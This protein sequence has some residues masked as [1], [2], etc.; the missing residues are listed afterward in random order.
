[1]PKIISVGIV[2]LIVIAGIGYQ[3]KKIVTSRNSAVA[4]SVATKQIEATTTSEI[5]NFTDFEKK[6]SIA[7]N[8]NI[9]VEIKMKTIMMVRWL[10][11]I[12]G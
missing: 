2:A 7:I 1:M 10:A 3:T 8:K 4:V 5:G 9:A 12:L 6:D 11:N